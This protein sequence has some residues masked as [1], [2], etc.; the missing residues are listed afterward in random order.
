[1]KITLKKLVVGAALLPICT[2]V[3]AIDETITGS[4][5]TIKDVTVSQVV[6]EEL[7]IN[8]LYLT[9][10]ATC[11]MTPPDTADGASVWVGDTKM[12]LAT[13]LPST[14]G[15][16]VGATPAA[17]SCAGVAGTIGIYEIDGASGAEVTVTLTAGT[18]SGIT[19]TPD[20]CVGDYD[21]GVDND[22]CTTFTAGSA[23]INLANATDETVS[24]T[25]GQPEEGKARIALGGTVATTIGLTA[26]T[27]YTVPFD[28]SV[29]Y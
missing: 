29:T 15:A 7:V 12:K 18:A 8:G 17:A 21:G 6:G 1:M 27:P 3:F 22:A 20:G 23:T 5:K 16:S 25:E 10:T 13:A 4:F 26:A 2:S 19:F 24:A 9:N 14:A 11:T 28:I